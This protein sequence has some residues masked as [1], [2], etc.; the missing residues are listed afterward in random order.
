[1]L[2][3]LS[4]SKA[5]ELLTQYGLNV[6]PEKHTPAVIKLLKNLISPIG[7]M[8]LL[9]SGLSFYQGKIFDGCFILALLAVNVGVTFWQEAKADNAIKKLNESLVVETNVLRDGKWIKID[10]RYVVPGDI[11]KL[12]SGDVIPADAKT[13]TVNN[14]S[15]N[16]SMLTGE[17]LPKDKKE[18]EIVYS[19]SFLVS[20]VL[21][22]EVTATGAGTYF[23]K[24]ISS[25]DKVRKRSLLEKDVIGITKFLSVLSIIAVIV[26]TTFFVLRKNPINEILQLDLTLLIAGIPI[27]LPTVMTLII[28]F[29]VIAMAAKNVVVRRLSS[30][31]DLSNVNYLLTDKTGTITQNKIEV[32]QAVS[33]GAFKE[34]DAVRYAYIVASND[35]N[36]TVN[37]AIIKKAEAERIDKDSFKVVGFEAFDVDKKRSFSEISENGK[38]IK[39]YI[40]AP[41]AIIKL[42]KEGVTTKRKF[43]EDVESLAQRGFKS[44]AVSVNGRL[45]GL[46]GFSDTLR[47][48]AKG[49]IQ[50]LRDNGI[51]VSVVTGDNHAITAEIIKGAGIPGGI[52]TKDEIEKHGWD[53]FTKDTFTSTSAFAEVLPD[54]KLN[55]VRIAKKYYVVASNGDGVNDLPAVKEANVGFA[56]ANA[57]SA[58]KAS[59]DIV[60]LSNGISVIKDA[61]IEGRKI[62]S[63][64]NTYAMYRI[65]ESE[66]LIITVAVLGLIYKVYPLTPLQLIILALLN[67]I[68]IISLAS[69][70]VK[71]ATSP[72]KIKMKER[73]LG[74]SLYGLVGIAN[75]LIL[76]F[77]MVSVLH[78]PW[79]IIQTIFFLKLTVSGHMLIYVAHTEGRWYK[80]L[81]SREILWATSITQAVASTFALTGLFM[82]S[83]ISIGW[84]IFVW[85][86]SFLFM[87]I[88]E[89]T[90]MLRARG[91]K[92]T[93]EVSITG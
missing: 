30:L 14:A 60:L 16:E 33:Y 77:L 4:S 39:I 90:K 46:L 81:P 11:V 69:D 35:D 34:E 41:Q 20:G 17:S 36:N 83:P 92:S 86:W 65:S 58:L 13:V 79:A 71:L 68:P 63:R 28:E 67:D 56:V 61:I 55:L 9:A 91:G 75:S 8:L 25:V 48:E 7:I 44:L 82:S 5:K 59:A 19:G 1:M 87:Q 15:V 57:V 47:P 93:A 84:V 18:G 64:L 21:F 10:S 89:V 29:G 3:G 40:G 80:F 27:S 49:V 2:S 76:F 42:C 32:S 62:F 72:S 24:T 66:R 85:L 88:A 45:A 70:K 74:S 38:D 54:D 78:L 26:L 23:G 53:K 52:V 31:E 73:F 12:T 37:Q 51:G 43:N 50:F 6:I 22:V